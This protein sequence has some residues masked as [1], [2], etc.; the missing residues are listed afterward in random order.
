MSET[1]AAMAVAE[2]Y[3]HWQL[4]EDD[5]K[6]VWLSLDRA[7]EST[8]TLG[9]E[10]L[11]ELRAILVSLQVQVPRGVVLQSAK[12]SGF[13]A[14]ADIREFENFQQA[15]I[16]SAKIRQGH[17]VLAML[18][19][20]SC[21][22]V[23]AVSGFCLGGGLELAMACDYIIAQDLPDTR[24]GLPEVKLGIFPGLGGTVRLTERCGG[25]QG[26]QLMLTGRLL[27]ARPARALNVIDQVI[28]RH[29]S[30]HWSARKAVLAGKRKKRPGMTA[31]LSNWLPARLLLSQ[32]MS[33]KTAQKVNPE[34]YPAP[35]RLIETWN[36]HRGSRE[37]MFEAEAREVGKLMVSDT[38]RGL[39]RVFHLMETLKSLGKQSDFSVRRVHVVGAGVMGGDIAAWCVAQGLEVTLQ[40]RDRSSIEPALQR[41]ARLFQ[42][43]LRKPAAVKAA[44]A[45]L[46]A[47]VDGAGVARADL[48]IEAIFENLDAKQT[49]YQQLEPRMKA[50]A[51]LATNTSA[52]PLEQL[53]SVLQQPQRFIGLHF[54]NPVTKMPLVEVVAGNASSSDSLQRGSAFCAQIN[55][56]GLP[57][58]SAPGFLVNRVLAPYLMEAMRCY[59]EGITKAT[60]DAA[61]ERFGMPM[62]PLELA[63]IVGLDVCRNVAETL[64]SEDVQQER[65]LLN[66]MIDAAQLGKK[67]GQ[68]FYLWRNGKAVK[69]RLAPIAASELDQLAQR[70]L[71]PFLQECE[72]ALQEQIVDSAELLDAGIIFGTG[73]APFRGGP[74]Y[75]SNATKGE[76][77]ND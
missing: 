38:A 3:R 42:K 11:A 45:R 1:G 67:S 28:D 16:V 63:D 35:F 39:R 21:P 6:I 68:G 2:H 52:I 57:V 64:I 55:R 34:H 15:H 19:S 43:R 74:L 76:Q 48:V 29:G 50:D 26:V 51:I 22:T 9:E 49:L 59:N 65:Q 13:I 75:Y 37:G 66:G 40:D 25:M 12:S 61:A 69:P 47:D 8:N 32:L 36:I 14:G 27:R 20:L 73:F 41:A 44:K 5:E 70:L 4:R 54:F 17:E 56:F 7:G 77:P 46:I 31:R 71:R 33:A 62:G 23:A 58:K 24:I 72:S 30:L 18:E 53:A 10:V 60:I